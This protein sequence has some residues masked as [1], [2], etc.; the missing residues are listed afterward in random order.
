MDHVVAS[1]MNAFAWGSPLAAGLSIFF[2]S[3]L[4]WLIVGAI[5]LFFCL[6]PKQ[7]ALAAF[8]AAVSCGLAWLTANGIGLIYFRLRPFA[9]HQDIRAL[10]VK[11]T[12]EKSFPSDHATCSFALA[13]AVFLVNKRWGAAFFAAAALVSVGRVLV[14]V[15]YPSDIV[16]G[17]LLG[18]LVAYLVHSLIHHLLGTRHH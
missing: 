14:G 2:A 18:C 8:S 1:A 17:A 3:H 11:S 10:V 9:E 13:T 6:A 12:L 4:V 16:V 15:H 7:R 5:A